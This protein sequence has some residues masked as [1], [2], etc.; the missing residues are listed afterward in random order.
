M[1]NKYTD[2]DVLQLS[3]EIIQLIEQNISCFNDKETGNVITSNESI[4]FHVEN[5]N[6]DRAYIEARNLKEY[7]IKLKNNQN[8]KNK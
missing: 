2:D 7:L 5:D 6:I 1:A 3:Y 4:S 8:N